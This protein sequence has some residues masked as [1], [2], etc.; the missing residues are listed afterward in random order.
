VPKSS[1]DSRASIIPGPVSIILGIYNNL[2]ILE[3]SLASL[4]VQS[5]RD[6]EIVVADDGSS[7]DYTSIFRTW[8]PRFAHGIHHAVHEKHG[9]RKA[10]ILNRAI[11]VSRFDRL[12]FIDTDCLAHRDFIRN[13]LTYL[14]PG[15]AITG[16]RSQ[17]SRDVIPKADRILRRGLGLGPGRLLLLWL[18]GK[19]RTLERAT[20]WPCYYEFSDTSVVGSNFSVWRTDLL[21]V[22]GFNEE[23]EGWGNEDWDLGL[24]LEFLGV[25]VRNLRNK[26][27]LYHL[28]HPLLPSDKARTDALIQRT[29]AERAPRARIGLAEIQP[30]DFT[31][32]RYGRDP[33]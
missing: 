19:A 4:A 15:T 25:R 1:P 23:F 17:L 9:F 21:A 33:H 22:N 8:A 12:I 5:W 10:R 3:P 28:T 31:L 29:K 18:R 26:V 20:V 27:V 11:S 16:R 6:F 13:H 32:V 2:D 14:K 30:G 24:R 7:Q